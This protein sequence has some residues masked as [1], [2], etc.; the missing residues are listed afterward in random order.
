[1]SKK[2]FSRKGE[3]RRKTVAEAVPDSANDFPHT[4]IASNKSS[5]L[6]PREFNDQATKLV[7]EDVA[8]IDRMKRIAPD[9]MPTSD[10]SSVS[11]KDV[12]PAW[13]EKKASGQNYRWL[14]IG[15]GIFLLFMIAM[16]VLFH[17]ASL[18]PTNTTNTLSTIEV[19]SEEYDP[20]SP[21]YIF[22][23]NPGK[24]Q[25]QCLDILS[26]YAAAKTLTEALPL[27]RTSPAI[28]AVLQKSWQT[29][30]SPPVLDDGT[31]LGSFDEIS[32][33][34]YFFITGSFTDGRNFTAYFVS[35]GNQ[36][37]LDWE[38][39][40][41]HS[42]ITLSELLKHPPEQPVM[43]RVTLAP[44]PYYIPSLRENDYESYRILDIHNELYA[45]GYVARNS[46]AH[47]HIQSMLLS[48]SVLLD[49]LPEA[50]AIVKMQKIKGLNR[51]NQFF[52]TDVLHKGWVMP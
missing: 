33:R 44:S 49:Q 24:A 7:I 29:W 32:G 28:K 8:V 38:A 41:G 22:Q 42:E 30:Q 36:L 39:T 12:E 14:W 19:I 34:A 4:L 11:R 50:Q 18:L 45:W 51:E 6:I 40:T 9:F 47:Q 17:F 25:Q 52:I 16:I 31:C 35:Q 13:I 20:Q 15:V 1:M 10:A 46:P 3:R 5:S 26:R 37:V 43:M 23:E 48:G 2:G 21:L 27:L